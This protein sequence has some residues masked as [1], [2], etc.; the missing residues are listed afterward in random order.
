MMSENAAII[1]FHCV[2]WLVFVTEAE[3]VYCAVRTEYLYVNKVNNA[4]HG[5]AVARAV[6]ARLALRRPG[7]FPE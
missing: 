5:R 3:Y 7:F 1:A 6:V 4:P 2:S